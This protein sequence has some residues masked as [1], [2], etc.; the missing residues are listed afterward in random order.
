MCVHVCRFICACK[1]VYISIHI[2]V[3]A[4]GLP[5]MLFPEICLLFLKHSLG[6]T[7]LARLA[8]Q[9]TPGTCYLHLLSTGTTS[10][11]KPDSTSISTSSAP[12]R[13][14]QAWLYLHLHL[15]STGTVSP[16]LTLYLLF[17]CL[18]SKHFT[19]W[20]THFESNCGQDMNLCKKNS[21][22]KKNK[23][24]YTHNK[25]SFHLE[26]RKGREDRGREKDSGRSGVVVHSFNPTDSGRQMQAELCEIQASLGYTGSY[27]LARTTQW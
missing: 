17:S 16:S 23:H 3:G 5:Q 22:Q 12:G 15:L 8:V 10:I 13:H 6:F 25:F 24:L 11:T 2:S 14:H 19:H 21:N 4:I 26:R 27:R 1:W 20:I 7:Y 9:E 18:S